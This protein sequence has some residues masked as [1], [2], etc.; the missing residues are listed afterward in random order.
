MD[1]TIEELKAEAD[2]LGIVYSNKIGTI[3]LAQKIEDY[4]ESQAAGDL[5]KSIDDESDEDEDEVATSVVKGP[6]M[7]AEVQMRTLIAKAREA[8]MA[9]R[10]V[11]LSS[12]DKQESEWTTTAYLSMENQHFG[13]SKIVPLDVPVELEQCL[14]DIAKNT[15]ITLHK[16][17]I[18][19]GR[20]TGNK[21]PTSVRKYNISYEDIEK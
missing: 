5:V 16:D 9:T 20:R 8:A 6:K 14:I 19:D 12:N 3:K 1:K 2:V 4:F 15:T 7:S 17:E 18:I 11:T 10:I 13:L 21:I